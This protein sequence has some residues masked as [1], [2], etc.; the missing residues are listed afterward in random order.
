MRFLIDPAYVSTVAFQ[1]FQPRPDYVAAILEVIRRAGAAVEGSADV[2]E[3]D[4][5]CWALALCTEV[6]RAGLFPESPLSLLVNA[7]VFT[8]EALLA[9]LPEDALRQLRE[10][11]VLAREH[12]FPGL[13][14]PFHLGPTFD[15]ST[16][17]PADTDLI[18]NGLLLDFKAGLKGNALSKDELYQLLGYTFFDRSDRYGINRIGIYAARFA[19][20][21]TWDLART[22]ELL[23]GEPVDIAQERETVWGLLG[24][25]EALEAKPARIR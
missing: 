20:L 19:A 10:L 17:C 8:P 7:D 24:G 2:A 5:G 14:A 23:T 4:A 16:L 15:G 25:T 12:L 13:A 6:Y 9:L 21:V 18:S 3:L 22:L 11:D 1:A